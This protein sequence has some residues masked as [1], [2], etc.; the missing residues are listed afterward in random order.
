MILKEG[1][2]MKTGFDNKKYVKIQSAKIKELED[3]MKSRPVNCPS[4]KG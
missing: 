1:E 3:K 4:E 2:K